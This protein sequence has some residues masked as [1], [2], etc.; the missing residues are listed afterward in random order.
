MK[1][2]P[3]SPLPDPMAALDGA[4]MRK[5]MEDIGGEAEVMRELVETFLEE[6]P[7]LVGLMRES[8]DGGD[9]RTL[10]RCAHSL[11]SSS[12]TFG[13]VQ[14]SRLCRDLEQATESATPQDADARVRD[15]QGEWALVEGELRAWKPQAQ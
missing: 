9:L 12:A 13:A 15:I 11:R 1:L 7:R 4:T 8:F 6:G 3:A 2:F 5:L 10:N 14:L